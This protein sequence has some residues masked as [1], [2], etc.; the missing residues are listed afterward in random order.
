MLAVIDYSPRSAFPHAHK[1]LLRQLADIA[2]DEIELLGKDLLLGGEIAFGKQIR[3]ATDSMQ[4][5]PEF[6][7]HVVQEALLGS[8]RAVG[9]DPCGNKFS[10]TLH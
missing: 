2:M 6:V 3:H 4:W 7:S 10:L 9:L 1:V 8:T 5:R